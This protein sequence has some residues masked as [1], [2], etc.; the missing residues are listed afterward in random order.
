MYYPI[1]KK[2]IHFLII[3]LKDCLLFTTIKP[4]AREKE[5]GP[6]RTPKSSGPQQEEDKW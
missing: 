6:H 1:L 4:K 5:S 3:E 2:K